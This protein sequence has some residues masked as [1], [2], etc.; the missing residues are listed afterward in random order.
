MIRIA[1]IIALSFLANG[2]FSQD[3]PAKLNN[4][5]TDKHIN[6]TGTDVW[7]IPPTKFI[8]SPGTTSLKKDDLN[9]IQVMLG[10][11]FD[12]A[13]AEMTIARF[14]KEN[15]VVN[16]YKYF[17]L[18]GYNVKFF[19]LQDEAFHKNFILCWG[20]SESSILIMAKYDAKDKKAEKE[21]RKAILG[22]VTEKVAK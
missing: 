8:L 10:E 18:N 11:N 20:N 4:T 6:I 15:T 19:W 7:I 17:K 21:V 13:T 2:L 22:V 1:F 14:E 16:E 5:K 9:S 3:I 12:K